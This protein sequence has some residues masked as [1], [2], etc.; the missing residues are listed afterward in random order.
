MKKIF[1]NLKRFDVPREMGGICDLTNP[2]KWIENIVEKSIEL[3]LGKLEGFQIVYM[4]PESLI[5]TANEKLK[6]YASE[7]RASLKIGS[8]SVYKDDI[9]KG[10]NFGAFTTKLPA[11]AASN[12]GCKDTIIAHS[13]ERKGILEILSMFEPELKNSQ[14]LREKAARTVDEIVNKEVLNAMD[15]GMDVLFCIGETEEERGEGNFEEQQKRI[16]K[17]L[18][19]QIENGLSGTEKYT[20]KQSVVIGYEPIWAIGPGKTPPGKEYIAYVSKLIK[21]LTKEIFGYELEVVYGGGL[22]EENAE[23]I[24][25]IDTIDGGLVALTKFTG[26]IGFYVEDLKIIIEKYI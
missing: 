17:V 25:S 4:I 16:K 20:G 1:I 2:K 5:I 13:E 15:Q 10:G 12:M 21:E 14:A 9:K 23:M 26:D 22:K 11:A 18:K 19:S 7:D 3:G 24:S 6:S 8:Q